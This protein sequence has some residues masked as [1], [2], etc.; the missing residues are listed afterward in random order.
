MVRA[1]QLIEG[2][3]LLAAP[4]GDGALAAVWRAQDT[5]LLREVAIE[6]LFVQDGPDP[7][8]RIEQFLHEA[9]MA[10]S[11]QHR[12]VVHIVDFGAVDAL[13]PF[14]VTE[15]CQG[16][17]LRAR[18][19]REPRL[20]HDDF[21][22][23]VSVAL[24]GLAA[25]H[26]AGIVHRDLKPG[27]IVLQRDADALSPKLLDFGIS[28]SLARS[29]V[30]PSP[31]ATPE[32]MSPEQVRGEGDIDERSDVYSMAVILYEGLTGELPFRGATLGEL[33]VQITT[34][35]P[36]SLRER[37]PELPESLAD[38]LSQA[39]AK[40]R[41]HR[42][43][44]AGAMRGA[45]LS[46]ARDLLPA[47]QGGATSLAP[48]RAN[49]TAADV[50]VRN[51]AA[52]AAAAAVGGRRSISWGEI[53][54]IAMEAGASNARA[55]SQSLPRL[56]V[57]AEFVPPVAGEARRIEQPTA[58]AKAAKATR[59]A[60]SAPVLEVASNT[61]VGP[62]VVQGSDVT[63]G[64]PAAAGASVVGR[65]SKT[66]A[67]SPRVSRVDAEHALD[68]LYVGADQAAPEIDYDRVHVKPRKAQIRAQTG[69]APLQVQQ[70]AAQRA[71]TRPRPLPREARAARPR[72]DIVWRAWLLPALA[73]ALLAY[74]FLTPGSDSPEVAGAAPGHGESP[75][76]RHNMDSALRR[77][78]LAVK[79]R[80]SNPGKLLPHLRD[81]EF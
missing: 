68:P 22:H 23:I 31:M 29:G 3:Y 58:A 6:F 5:T 66:H 65:L 64:A 77:M 28:R 9:R 1:G 40:D 78:R 69:A 72:R 8:A 39:M 49:A 36:P 63:P 32:Y 54:G 76:A 2:R 44:D 50:P 37:C 55:S 21:V 10:A 56:R 30:G 45:L 19:A 59:A 80:R 14:L 33:I 70:P 20:R 24:R 12:D 34:A 53:E 71:Q 35:Q 18:M 61:P 48:A 25:L 75:V 15:L 16:E 11:V 81:V 46:A 67:S 62:A 26:D 57:S 52:S 74:A 73:I 13:Q 4:I 47:A 38:M 27:S 41:E 60:A 17:S 43:A 7:G 42:F 79:T 51:A